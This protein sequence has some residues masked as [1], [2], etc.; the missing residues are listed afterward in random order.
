MEVASM[1]SKS[2]ATL[3]LLILVVTPIF[4]P[5]TF[6]QNK[7]APIIAPL[8]DSEVAGLFE[9]MDRGEKIE[10]PKLYQALIGPQTALR[11][12]AAR[13]LGKYGDV[14]SIPYLI[15]ALA[16]ESMHV[17]ADYSNPGMATTRYWA[18]DS[19]VRLTGEDF[20]FVWNDPA[21]KRNA[22]IGK[23]RDWYNTRIAPDLDVW[24]PTLQGIRSS[25]KCDRACYKPGDVP[26]FTYRL[27]NTSETQIAAV[28]PSLSPKSEFPALIQFGAQRFDT[29]GSRIGGFGGSPKNEIRAM[30]PGRNEYALMP[31]EKIF[32]VD[33][34]MTD[35]D[36]KEPVK[37]ESGRYEVTATYF[38][39]ATTPDYTMNRI[40]RAIMWAGHHLKTNTVG[41]IVAQ[42]ASDKT[43]Y[44]IGVREA[45][46]E[47]KNDRLSW[48]HIGKPAD[49]G[50]MNIL[51]SEY[52]IDLLIAADC[53]VPEAVAEN[54]SG[55]NETMHIEIMNRYRQDVVKLAEQKVQQQFN[56]KR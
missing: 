19:L 18:N 4:I 23:W 51:K 44:E 5:D 14:S 28:L 16:D 27:Q 32:S 35:L 24:G 36:L 49:Q 37:L 31:K 7:N 20:R 25:L 46:Y 34:R 48:K 39:R 33:V 13:E 21:D 8:P 1:K 10:I 3:K 47:I 12:F 50:F 41:F 2:M 26:I 22:S 40:E 53:H 29:D 9:R 17:G 11:A 42:N 52:H 54:V 55:Y 45:L 15:D 38:I 43:P 56:L 30:H 6:A